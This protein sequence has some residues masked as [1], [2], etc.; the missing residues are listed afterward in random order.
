MAF[1]KQIYTINLEKK[2]T[3][4]QYWIRAFSPW[5]TVFPAIL[6]N[7]ASFSYSSSFIE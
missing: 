6:E 5:Y 3:T 1:A 4:I 7:K 2:K